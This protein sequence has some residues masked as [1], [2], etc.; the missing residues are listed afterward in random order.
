MSARSLKASV[1]A[2][3][4]HG[5][6]VSAMEM[7]ARV[8]LCRVGRSLPQRE[9]MEKQTRDMMSNVT[10]PRAFARLLELLSLHRVESSA[11]DITVEICSRSYPCADITEIKNSLKEAGLKLRSEYS[12]CAN[13]RRSTRNE[14]ITVC[15]KPTNETANMCSCGKRT[16][17]FAIQNTWYTANVDAEKAL[18]NKTPL[19]NACVI[20][21]MKGTATSKNS[22]TDTSK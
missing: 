4:K 6:K 21:W 19:C 17:R 10:T 12:S 9:K 8:E 5:A 1:V 2:L 14:E 22:V 16:T 3:K 7:D 13:C 11:V 20:E 15:N 18:G